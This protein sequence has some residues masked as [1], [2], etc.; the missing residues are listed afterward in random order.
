MKKQSTNEQWET[1]YSSHNIQLGAIASF[2][3]RITPK[4]SNSTPYTSENLTSAG[5]S[6]ASLMPKQ[7]EPSYPIEL[8][9]TDLKKI[10]YFSL[11]S[12]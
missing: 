11:A 5:A 6:G 12:E 10:L 1:S 3:F 4:L 2:D 7:S 9:K 8:Y